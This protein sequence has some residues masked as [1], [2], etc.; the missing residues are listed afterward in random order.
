M[1]IT[2]APHLQH[3]RSPA[4]LRG[5]R[6]VGATAIAV[7]A[8]LQLLLGPAAN[9]NAGAP[10]ARPYP[11]DPNGPTKVSG[12]VTHPDQDHMGF[13]IAAHEGAGQAL[14]P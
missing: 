2:T 7:T 10:D 1:A 4:R 9:A 14:T 6:A 5:R 3:R 11:P 13:T 8:C 12:P